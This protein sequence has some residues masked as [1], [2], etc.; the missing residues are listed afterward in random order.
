MAPPELTGDWDHNELPSTVR[1]GAGCWLERK[2]SFRSITSSRDP[3]VVLGDR[4]AVYT[5]TSLTVEGQGLLEV[6]DDAVLV[7]AVVMCADHIRIGARAAL[8]YHVTVADSD[9][10][11]RDPDL[12]RQDAYA[13][14]PGGDRRHRPPIPT[15]PVVIGDDARVGIGAIIL[16]GVTV[17]AGAHIAAGA[18]VTADVPAGGA[19]AGNPA[20]PVAGGAGVGEVSA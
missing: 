9:F 15:R 13:N 10:H 4:V 1:L 5:W 17:G 11:P 14:A 3:A 18:V 16:K 12:R 2:A 20:V 6:D 19:V 8:S 7:G